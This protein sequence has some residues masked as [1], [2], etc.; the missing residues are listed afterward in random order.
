VADPPLAVEDVVRPPAGGGSDE[1]F[2]NPVAAR[3]ADPWVLRWAGGYYYCGASRGAVRVGRSERLHE[4]ARAP[5]AAVWTPP[6]G[7]P[8]SRHLWAP[9]LHRLDGRFYIYVAADDGRNERHRMYVL[10]GE[11]DDPQRPFRLKGRIACPEDRWAIDGTVLSL[12]DGPRF[13]VWSG[14]EAD[15]NGRQS[16]YV[17]PMSNPWT[18][19]GSRVRIST[20]E[21]PWERGSRPLVNEGPSVLRGR[22]GRVFLVYSA[23]GSWTDDYCLGL[24]SLEGKDPLQPRAWRKHERPIFARTA[25]VFGPGHA[26]FTRSPDDAEDWIVYHAARHRG[27]GWKRDVRMQRIGWNADG[28]P[29]L[30][31]PVAPGLALEPPSGTRAFERPSDTVA[32]ATTLQEAGR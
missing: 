2:S 28:W 27:S 23:G 15:V 8:W 5:R 12:E 10:E 9:E 18:I 29:E 26:S 3:G 20:P 13:F 31:I 14:W 6:R 25:H 7:T 1:L 17:A 21:L 16:L 30:G 24:L 11:T 22:G 19:S 4:V 32:L